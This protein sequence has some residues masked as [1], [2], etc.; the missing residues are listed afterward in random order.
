MSQAE[1]KRWGVLT[2]AQ[3]E[4]IGFRDPKAK[5]EMAVGDV[6]SREMGTAARANGDKPDWSLMSLRQVASLMMNLSIIEKYRDDFSTGSAAAKLVDIL[7][8]FQEGLCSADQLLFASVAYHWDQYED[9]SGGSEPSPLSKVLEPVIAVWEY[10]KIKYSEFNWATGAKW[11]IPIGSLKRHIDDIIYDHED[12]DSESLELH[13]AHIVCNAMM[14]VHY[15]Q[16][17]KKGDDRPLFAFPHPKEEE[18]KKIEGFETQSV[19]DKIV[20]E[21]G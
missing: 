7:G 19:A 14:L 20:W 16:F 10:G 17:W 9:V 1:P 13:S 8:Q 18:T 3:K 12:F 5:V 6:N 2:D 15:A 11:S 4:A 21:K